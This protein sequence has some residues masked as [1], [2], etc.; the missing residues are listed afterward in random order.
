MGGRGVTVR[1]K[2][3]NRFRDRMGRWRTYY[4]PPGAKGI[5]LPDLE[6]PGFL[7]AY[8]AAV[9]AHAATA[10]RETGRGAEGTFDR[11]AWTYFKS[12]DYAALRPSTQAKNR[13]LIDRFCAEHGHRPVATMTRDNVETIIRKKAG[14]P[15]GANNLLKVLRML[16]GFAIARGWR[17]DD[18]TAKIKKFKE[19][20]HHT[21]TDEELA[22][23][24]ARWPLGTRE[25]LAYAI[26]LYTGQR[27]ADVAAMSWGAVEMAAGI[28][29][30][31]Q[32]KTGTELTIPMH[33]D[34]RR[35]LEGETRRG[36]TIV[37]RNDGRRL[38]VES[39]GN[40]MADA[41]SEAGLDERC[42]LHGL[43]KA[44]GR[45]LAEAGCSSRQIMAIL[46]HKTL[47]EAERYTAAAEQSR[48]A[49]AA[50]VRLEEHT[51]TGN[52]QTARK[53]LPN[54]LKK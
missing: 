24:E 23:F 28:V 51:G 13:G 50:I 33:Q 49:K 44:A 32:E 47:E 11:L 30:V 26:A 37:A 8:A 17:T 14:T 20:T 6:D 9:A 21:W 48:L 46:G 27:R 40:F 4:R 45:R 31:R 52:L 19:G 42:V 10:P 43:R 5:P 38:T 54:K 34:L 3:I 12:M 16:M 41:I 36:L 7:A 15:A 22:R 2:H 25:R 39:F 29:R 53:K 18:P 35:A 1:P